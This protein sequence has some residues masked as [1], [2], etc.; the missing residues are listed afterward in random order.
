MK[1]GFTRIWNDKKKRYLWQM[2]P[3]PGLLK[4]CYVEDGVTYCPTMPCEGALS[5]GA[6]TARP[7][8][9]TGRQGSRWNEIEAYSRM[10]V[11]P[12]RA[13]ARARL[14]QAFMDLYNKGQG[15][16]ANSNRNMAA[17]FLLHQTKELRWWCEHADMNFEDVRKR[18]QE[19]LAGVPVEWRKPAGQSARFTKRKLYRERMKREKRKD[20]E[21]FE[22]AAPLI[23]NLQ[24]INR[25]K[26]KQECLSLE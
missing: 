1:Q 6:I 12:L 7:R 17:A 9:M 4:L 11:H 19:I 25:K 8:N 5:W 14:V 20:D 3:R 22:Q 16:E 2:A 23:I 18:A 13:I 26:R 10:T 24:N 21:A 15:N